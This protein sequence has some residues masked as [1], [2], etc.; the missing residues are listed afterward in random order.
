M[1]ETNQLMEY[2]KSKSLTQ[3]MYLITRIQQMLTQEV[4]TETLL[5]DFI[6]ECVNSLDILYRANQFKPLD[7]RIAAMYF[8]NEAINSSVDLRPQMN[9]WSM[10]T[11]I[12]IRN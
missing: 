3:M 6:E 12:Q 9:E 1:K 5:L 11:K 2:L 7:L 4:V 10:Q 8:H